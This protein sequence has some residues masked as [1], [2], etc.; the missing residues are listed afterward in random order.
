MRICE[1]LSSLFFSLF[2]CFFL[3]SYRW[4]E[5]LDWV[6]EPVS[7]MSVLS[8]W[9]CRLTPHH[10]NN[11]LSLFILSFLFLSFFLFYKKRKRE[12]TE[13]VRRVRRNVVC[14][15]LLSTSRLHKERKH[16]RTDTQHKEKHRNTH[17]EKHTGWPHGVRCVCRVLGVVVVVCARLSQVRSSNSRVLRLKICCLNFLSLWWHQLLGRLYVFALHTVCV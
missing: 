16:T 7:G 3:S 17:I 14:H 11:S 13:N 6:S 8:G 2:F 5:E 10:N 1:Q 12:K 4:G 15:S 9:V